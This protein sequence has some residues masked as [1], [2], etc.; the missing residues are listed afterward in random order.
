MYISF[1]EV[2]K[3]RQEIADYIFLQKS[4]KQFTVIDVGGYAIGWSLPV[5][6]AFID[7]Q[8]LPT[9]KPQFIFD[10]CKE[11]NW[12]SVIDFVEKNGKFDYCICTHTLEDIYN[13]YTVLDY[14]PKIAKSGVITMPSV[15]TET[16]YIENTNW[17]GFAHH[18]Y[19]FGCKDQKMIIAPKLPLVEKLI[20]R[21]S[22]TYVEEIRYE[23][24]NS[25]PYD[26][27]M[28]NYLGPNTETVLKEYER[29]IREQ[30]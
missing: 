5:A 29:F 28:S 26:I 3:G 13:P 22:L 2:M 8:A 17:C 19:L 27:F 4:K 30:I 10:I 24:E 14:L 25:I 23:W 11:S 7:I 15:K 18:R 20:A 16:N 1:G 6:D 21:K 12:L 9:K